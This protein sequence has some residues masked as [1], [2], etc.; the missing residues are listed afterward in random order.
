MAK[1]LVKSEP[2]VYSWE[3]FVQDGSTCWD[4]VRNYQARNNL[5]AMQKGD[6]VFFYHSNEGLAIVGIARVIR[7]AYPDPTS[8]D[9]RWVAVDL[10]P[11][12]P[13]PKPVSLAEMKADPRLRHL[14]LLRQPRL[15]VCPV[16]ESEWQAILSLGGVRES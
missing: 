6:E 15:S 7:M 9:S 1:W 16:T 5:Q 2:F 3:Q 4:G 11:V 13:L 10:E 14:A 12:R 8:D